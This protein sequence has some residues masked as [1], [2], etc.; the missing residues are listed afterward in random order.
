MSQVQLIQLLPFGQ[1]DVSVNIINAFGL[2]TN[3]FKTLEVYLQ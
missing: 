1:I 2:E 3:A